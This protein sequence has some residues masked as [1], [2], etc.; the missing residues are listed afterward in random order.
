M[1]ETY[2]TYIYIHVYIYIFISITGQNES[3]ATIT[4][5]KIQNLI[6]ISFNDPRILVYNEPG[7][8]IC[9]FICI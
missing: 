7:I 4:L 3:M 5:K 6:T 2:Y 1:N 8:Y 9:I